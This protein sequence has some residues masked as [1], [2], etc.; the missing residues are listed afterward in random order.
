MVMAVVSGPAAPPLAAQPPVAS[1]AAVGAAAPAS[2]QDDPSDFEYDLE[3]VREELARQG[4]GVNWN[5][6]DGTPVFRVDI[7]KKMPGIEAIIGDV[8]ALQRGPWVSSPYHQEFLDM[9]T[10]RDVRNSFTN[11]ELLQVLAT[12]LAGGLALQG[13][14]SAIKNYVNGSRTREACDAVRT[15]LLDLNRD[16]VAAGLEPVFV[17]GC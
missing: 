4:S 17:P 9:V 3:R 2:S 16:R 11:S 15:T 8:K 5:L 12:G 1:G 7:Q 6:P 13:I 10:P 14:T